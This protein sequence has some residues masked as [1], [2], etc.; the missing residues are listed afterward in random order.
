MNRFIRVY[1]NKT[2]KLISEVDV[3]S[4][5]LMKFQ[6]LFGVNDTENPMFDCFEVTPEIAGAIEAHLSS[7]PDWNFSAYSYFLETDAPGT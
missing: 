1:S 2:D 7:K 3:Q 5:D 4:F 6:N